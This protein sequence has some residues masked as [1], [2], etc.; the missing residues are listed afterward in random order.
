[1]TEI[2]FRT[3]DGILSIEE[4]PDKMAR[5]YA[6]H[7]PVFPRISKVFDEH[8]KLV[9]FQEYRHYERTCESFKGVPV[10]QEV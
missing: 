6:I 10:F 7:R 5:Q 3:L 9:K 1:M 8:T 2:A 4:W